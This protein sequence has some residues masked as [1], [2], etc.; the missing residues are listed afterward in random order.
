MLPIS[1]RK[2]DVAVVVVE[3]ADFWVLVRSTSGVDI[4]FELIDRLFQRCMLFED[5]SR[6]L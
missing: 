6:V 5:F 1:G 3:C 4:L 2:E